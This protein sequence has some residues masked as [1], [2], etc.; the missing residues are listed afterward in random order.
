MSFEK[1]RAYLEA[2]GLAAGA[3]LF[4]IS[5]A[6]VALAA[7]AVGCAPERIA[8]TLSFDVGGRPVL[9]VAAGDARIDNA[10]FKAAF[11]QKATMLAPERVEALVGYSVGGVC[12]FGV[13]DGVTI[14]LDESL[15][16]FETVFPA[17][18]SDN[19]AVELTIDQLQRAAEGC[20]WVDVCKGWREGAD[21]R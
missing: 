14:R 19:S 1:A 3:R 17:C 7:Q 10:R 15:R 8:K 11:G 13:H 18:G 20:R 5:S 2:R 16:R 4:A 12:P 6:T 9:I 21:G